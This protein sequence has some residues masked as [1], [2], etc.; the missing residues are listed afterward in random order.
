LSGRLRIAGPVDSHARQVAGIEDLDVEG[1]VRLE[2]G[3]SG[4]LSRPEVDGQLFTRYG[5]YETVATDAAIMRVRLAGDVLEMDRMMMQMGDAVLQGSGTVTSLYDSPV[6]SVR[7][8]ANDIVLQDLEVWRNIGLPLS[9]R[10]S[11]PYLSIEGPLDD[12]KGLAQVQADD[13]VL[14]GE[15]IGAVDAWVVLDNQSLILRRTTLA[16]AGGEMS[17]QGQYRLLSH[18]ILPSSVE[19]SGVSVPRLLAAARP[20]AETFV[21]APESGMSLADR[22]GSLAMRLRGTVDGSFSLQGLLPEAAAPDADPAHRP[23]LK[24]ILQQLAASVKLDMH[25]ARYD[26]KQLPD[27]QLSAE[28]SDEGKVDLSVAATRGEAL[29]TADGYWDPDGQVDMLAEVYAL[30]MATL[31]EWMPDAVRSLGGQLNL[32]VKISGRDVAPELM[33]SLDIVGPEVQGVRLDLLSAPI[34]RV[35]NGFIDVDSLVLRA[36]DQEVF[37][38][39]RVPFDWEHLI[40]PDGELSITARTENTD[41]GLFPPMIARALGQD[42]NSPLSQL[43]AKGT[44]NSRVEIS[45]TAAHPKLS[46]E[47]SIEG[48]QMSASSLKTPVEDITLDA[49]F[50]AL[51][52]ETLLDVRQFT[53]RADQVTFTA[54]GRAHMAAFRPSQLQLNRYDLRAEVSSP[55]QEMGAGL[56]VTDLKGAVTLHTDDEGRQLVTVEDLGAKMGKGRIA[57]GGDVQI[58]SFVP[59]EATRNLYDLILTIDDARPRYSNIFVGTLNGVITARTPVP[60][61]PVVIAGGV[62]L[63]HATIGVPPAGQQTARELMGMPEWFPSPSFDLALDIGEDVKFA[64]T[65]IV[66]PLEPREAAVTATGTPQRPV[67]SGTI[68]VQK[69]RASVPAGALDV[70]TAGVRFMIRPALGTSTSRPPIKL[71]MEGNIWGNAT[72]RIPRAVIGGRNVGTVDVV[73]DVSGTLPDQI[74]VTASS[75]PPLAEEQIFGLLGAQQLMGSFGGGSG[76]GLSDVM[77]RRFVDAL[78]A[79]FRHYVFQPFAEDLKQMLGLSMLEVSFAFDQAVQIKVGKYLVQDLLVTY[80]TAM[81]GTADEWEMGVSYKVSDRYEVSFRTDYRRDSQML[82]QYIR[83]F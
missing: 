9:G 24:Q 44:V 72:K 37:V 50:S 6:V 17:L 74:H 62:E 39:G 7:L 79:A 67:I 45:G 33:G 52:D 58:V 15:E 29:I 20:V 48:G 63:S 51:D 82:V 21:P 57:L 12:L 2:A 46:G 59:S 43:V 27:V 4:T 16:L 54:G 49:R 35:A 14:G 5:R 68:E 61:K 47:L 26:M 34:I 71:T 64:T 19:L 38:D 11:L 41:L 75:I 81:L 76:E 70:G 80:Q 3:V 66:A 1:A 25:D 77:S 83:T 73:L 60:G 42:E 78:G 56:V 10:V 40:P 65:G 69:G 18:E 13:L 31:R 28:V 30:D 55:R 22:L 32:S 23:T 36:Q 53:A 8:N